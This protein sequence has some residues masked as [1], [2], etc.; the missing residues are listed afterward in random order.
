MVVVAEV[1]QLV[2]EAVGLVV[3]KVVVKV[4]VLV[5]VLVVSDFLQVQLGWT[6]QLGLLG[7]TGAGWCYLLWD[8]HT[9]L[10]SAAVHCE[11]TDDI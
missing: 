10:V 5:T 9:G 7:W 4:V 3:V 6:E 1:L 8:I 2:A 11:L